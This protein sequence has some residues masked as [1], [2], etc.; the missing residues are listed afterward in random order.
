MW[1]RLP[2]LALK[3]NCSLGKQNSLYLCPVN[4]SSDCADVLSGSWPAAAAVERFSSAL[5]DFQV[6][7]S[8]SHGVTE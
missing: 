2:G 7:C 3:G 1:M 5:V 4:L 6:P 8:S